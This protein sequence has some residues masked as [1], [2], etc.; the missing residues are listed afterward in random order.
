MPFLA[1]HGIPVFVL[2]THPLPV[3]LAVAYF[4]LDFSQLASESG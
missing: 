3:D 4:I 2:A 1:L